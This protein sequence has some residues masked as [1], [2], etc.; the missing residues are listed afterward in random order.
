MLGDRVIANYRT[1][2]PSVRETQW[3]LARE[4]LARAVSAAPSARLKASLRYCEGHLHRIDGEA[5]KA[6]GKAVEAQQEF[7]DAVTAFREAAELRPNWPTRSSDSLERS[8]T[9]WRTSIA[10][11]TR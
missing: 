7:T 1:A 5:R 4:A 10:A 3:R 11:R 6:R 9:G 8:S 2:L